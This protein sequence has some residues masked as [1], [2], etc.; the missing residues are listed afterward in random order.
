MLGTAPLSDAR[1]V[2][3]VARTAPESHSN[4]T[5]HL[6]DDL[7]QWATRP[8]PRQQPAVVPTS[9]RTRPLVASGTIQAPVAAVARRAHASAATRGVDT[10]LLALFVLLNAGDLASTYLGLHSGMREG[11]PLMGALLTQYGFGALI[12]YKLSVIAAVAA[13]ILFLRT[14]HRRVAD[15]T[16]GICNV[17]VLL[18]VVVNLAQYLA[19]R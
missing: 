15:V 3:H 10:T 18:V 9:A 12:V 17:L 16:I 19:I 1:R 2:A 7:A 4:I 14:F 8:L 13:G 11:N 6:Y 5:A